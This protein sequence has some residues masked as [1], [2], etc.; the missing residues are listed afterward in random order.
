MENFKRYCQAYFKLLRHPFCPSK[1]VTVDP[2][3]LEE[4]IDLVCQIVGAVVSEPRL[5]NLDAAFDAAFN[6][7]LIV[8]RDQVGGLHNA[9]E[10]LA[11]FLEPFLKKLTYLSYPDRT[12]RKGQKS[13]PLWHF[14]MED[15][16]YT[17][18]IAEPDLDKTDPTYWETQPVQQAMWRVALISRHKGAHEAHRYDLVEIER[19]ATAVIG[20]YLL[21]ARF[22]LKDET[23]QTA[24]L[25][26]SS[27]VRRLEELISVRAQ[28]YRITGDLP[29]KVEHLRLY[30]AR[31]DISVGK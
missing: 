7:Y 19:I 14:G 22:A 9:V 28:T 10:R 6:Q 11:G 24:A 23:S 13:R 5:A 21:S 26:R 4:A 16:L 1:T 17:L 18:K 25:L 30:S 27:E 12:C 20:C 8:S 2:A 29:G 15:I 3:E 31:E